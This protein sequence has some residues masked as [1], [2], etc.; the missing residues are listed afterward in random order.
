ME[1]VRD[2]KGEDKGGRRVGRVRKMEEGG[3]RERG[4]GGGIG[5]IR[6]KRDR[7]GEL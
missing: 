3:K 4:E 5:K 6:G 7:E 2:M 1:I